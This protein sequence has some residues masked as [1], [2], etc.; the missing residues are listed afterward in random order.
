MKDLLAWRDSPYRKPLLLTGVRQCG[1]TWLLK[2]F[3]RQ[4]FDHLAYVNFDED[5]GM[6]ELFRATKDPGRLIA[7]LAAATGQPIRPGQT[8]LVLDEIQDCPAALNALKYFRESAPQLHVAAAGSLLGVAL[9][10]SGFPVGQV[11]FLSLRPMTLE[12]FLRA[13]DLG[14]LADYLGSIET[15]EPVPQVFAAPLSEQL[16][17]FFVTGGLPEPVGLWLAQ[18]DVGLVQTALSG[19]I[20]SYERDF[21]KYAPAADFP[22]LSLIWRSLPSQ[23]SRENQKFLYQAVKPGARARQFEDAVEW[24]VNAGLVHKVFRS[25]APGLPLGA[26]DDLSAFKLY[27]ADVGVLRRLSGLAPSAF[28]EGDRLFRE[29]RGALTENYVLQ[30]LVGQFEATPRYWS[31]LNPRYEV[32]FLIQ[33]GNLVLPVEAKAGEALASKSLAYFDRQFQPLV[34]V[35]LSMAN[36]ALDGGLLNIPLYLADQAQRLIGLAL[37]R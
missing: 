15:F 6:A 2:Q 5:P 27:A 12:E 33:H 14:N 29:F 10:G 13:G 17:Q 28:A 30:C 3:G 25:S 7:N 21:A 8:L 34:R 24:L 20:G 36:L 11:D 1:K 23:L 32:D 9:A 31:R 35:R 37:A 22:K 16:K 4:G 18:R 19:I 26:Y